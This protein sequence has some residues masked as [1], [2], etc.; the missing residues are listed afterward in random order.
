[1]AQGIAII[2][3]PDYEPQRW[4][5]TLIYWLVLLGAFAINRWGAK[6]LPAIEVVSMALHVIMFFLILI[7]TV[8]VTPDR[9]SAEYVF[10]T[11]LNFSGWDNDGIAWCI[12]LLTSSYVMVGAD[13]VMHMSEEMKEPRKGIP[14]AMI[15]SLLINGPMGFAMLIALLFSMGDLA[16]AVNS[17]TGFPIIEIF[18]HV[19]RGNVAAASAMTASIVISA[20]LATVALMASASRTLWACARDDLPPFSGWLSHLHPTHHIP[21]NSMYC[22]LGVLVILG[23]LQIASTAAFNAYT[24]LAVVSLYLSYLM[25][26]LGM[27]YCRIFNPSL[28]E[29]GPWR[30]GPHMGMAINIAAVCYLIIACLFIMLPPTRPVTALNMNYAPVILGASIIFVTVY[31]FF[32]KDKFSARSEAARHEAEARAPQ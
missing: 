28:L 10:T 18:L 1:M 13:S 24:S 9:H 6:I 16:D 30:L 14:R 26:I 25:P 23:L 22:T 12:G 32:K 11:F 31:W 3:Y 2:N 15:G 17:S 29:F 19:T 27:L 4:H 20:T 5:G 8:V 21:T 7:P